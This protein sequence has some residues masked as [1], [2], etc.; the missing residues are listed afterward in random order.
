MSND[1]DDFEDIVEED[2]EALEK[3][4]TSDKKSA[5]KIE[6]RRQVDDLLEQRRLEKELKDSFDD[7]DDNYYDEF[8]DDE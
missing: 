5:S 2:D 7:L 4:L 8:D 1:I 6:K 3:S